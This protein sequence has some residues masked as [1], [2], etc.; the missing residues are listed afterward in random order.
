[1]MD[2]RMAR[3]Y[4]EAWEKGEPDFSDFSLEEFQAHLES[5]PVC[6][7][8][9]GRLLPFVERDAGIAGATSSQERVESEANAIP[10]DFAD[11]VMR[12]IEIAEKHSRTPR[13]RPALV[14]SAAAAAVFILGLGLGI[15]FGTRKTDTVNVKFVL[16]APDASVVELAGD[17]SSWNPKEYRLRKIAASGQW[18]VLVPL[19][20]GR[21]YVYNFVIDGDRWIEDPNAAVKVDDGFGGSSSLLRL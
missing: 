9:F 10:A 16:Y 1:M 15:Y 8:E 13:V 2:C 7:H 20:K 3:A 14:A 4:I 12:K 11:T 19:K 21:V 5:C 18:E 6:A 17:F